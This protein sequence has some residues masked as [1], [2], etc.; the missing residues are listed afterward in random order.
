MKILIITDIHY[1]ED[2]NYPN[3]GGE[4]YINSFGSQFEKYLPK[5][6]V[7]IKEYD[8]VIDLGDLISEK[9]V[10]EDLVQYKKATALFGNEKPVKHVL[11][12]HELRTLTREQIAEM[13]GEKKPYYSFDLCGYH[14]II[15]DSFRSSRDEPCRIEEEQLEWLKADINNTQ[16]YNCRVLSLLTR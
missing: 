11:G 13:I 3:Y 4:D 15:L 7:L 14:H 9:G 1:G 10:E 12:N 6:H 8:L 2:T 16:S 5:I